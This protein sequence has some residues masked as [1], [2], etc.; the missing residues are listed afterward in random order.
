[1]KTICILS[2]WLVGLTTSIAASPS[3]EAGVLLAA[4]TRFVLAREVHAQAL[5]LAQPLP[6]A[7]ARQIAD[8]A[9]AWMTAE[10]EQLRTQLDARFGEG[11]RDRFAEF[12]SSYTA[13]EGTNDL[14]YLGRL[15][16]DAQ[17]GENPLEFSALRRLVL[18]KWLADSFAAGGQLLGEMQTWADLRSKNPHTPPLAAWL[19]RAEPVATTAPATPAKPVNPLAAAEADVPEFIPPPAGPPA[20]PM[21]AF[22]QS[23]AEKRDRALQDAQAGMQQMAMERQGAEQEYAAKKMAEAQA[24][25]EAMRAQAQK[26]AAVEQEAIDQRAN[27]WMGRLKN[28]VSATVGAATGAFTG[29]IGAEAG[30]QAANA[31]FPP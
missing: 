17:L 3:T 4:Y 23:R 27:S 24:D 10:T 30:R 8:Q 7:D 16:G 29:G 28:I 11:A 15:A 26:L 12:V 25:A 9:G 19:A 22:A 18:D 2:L 31:L 20:N 1:M 13:A 5:N 14:H 6:E 21:D